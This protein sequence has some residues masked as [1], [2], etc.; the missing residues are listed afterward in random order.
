MNKQAIRMRRVFMKDTTHKC[1]SSFFTLAD[2]FVNF[3][4]LQSNFKTFAVFFKLIN[5]LY[6]F[7]CGTRGSASYNITR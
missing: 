7:N 3:I 6:V 1:P 4:K 5:F 2:E